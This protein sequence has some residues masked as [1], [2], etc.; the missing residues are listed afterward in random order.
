MRCDHYVGLNAW[1]KKYVS[2]KRSVREVGVRIDPKSGEIIGHIDRYFRLPRA[3]AV[4][5]DSIPST[6]TDGKFADLHRYYFD[7]GSFVEEFL[8]KMQWDHGPWHYIALRNDHH[9]IL[10][11]SLWGETVVEDQV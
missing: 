2:R 3:R 7:D 8:E 5:Y 11:E 4:V 6:Y 1:A 9:E 10:P